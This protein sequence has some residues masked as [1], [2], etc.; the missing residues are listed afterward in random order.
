MPEARS[1]LE[2]LGGAI[3]EYNEPGRAL[4]MRAFFP[5]AAQVVYSDDQDNFAYSMSNQDAILLVEDEGYVRDV[6]CEIL[7]SAGYKVLTAKS[8]L[9]ALEIFREQGPVRLL[10]TDVVMPG[11]DGRDLAERLTSLQPELKTIYMSG[12]TDNAVLRLNLQRPD[13]V[14]IQKPFTLDT[15]T[16][17]VKDVLQ[18]GA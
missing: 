18:A 14:Y 8:G 9:E 7:E 3:C 12:Y 11:M 16:T 6:A 10:V 1:I 2:S 15:L 5:S 13:V 4:T 17:T